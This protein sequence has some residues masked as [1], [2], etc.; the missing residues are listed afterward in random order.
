MNPLFVISIIMSL[1]APAKH[2]CRWELCPYKE[3]TIKQAPESVAQYVGVACTEAYIIDMLHIKYPALDA[4]Q[5]DSLLVA[6]G[7]KIHKLTIT[8]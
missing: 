1:C 7:R 6:R 5:L 3:I 4:D 2:T 8:H